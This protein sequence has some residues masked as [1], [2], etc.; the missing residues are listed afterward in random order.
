M[1]SQLFPNVDASSNKLIEEITKIRENGNFQTVKNKIGKDKLVTLIN[2]FYPKYDIKTLEKFFKVPDS[3][4]GHWFNDLGIRTTRRHIINESVAANFEHSDVFTK[5]KKAIKLSAVKIT[6]DLA[7]LIGFTLGDGAVQ[8]YMVEVFNQDRGMYDYLLNSMKKLGPVTLDQREDGLWRI[9]LSSRIISDLIKRNKLMRQ[10][11]V[12]F[13]LSDSNL[14]KYFLAALWDAEGSVLKQGKYTHI[15]FYNSNKELIDLIV[16]YLNTK[17]I[18]SSILK[19]N[20]RRKDYFINGH[21][22]KP[23]KQMY[24]IGIPKSDVGKWANEIGLY[25]LHS[26]KKKVVN[27]II[28]GA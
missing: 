20:E 15:Y 6:P 21:L 24:R 12:D 22:V 19:L 10:E 18:K 11:T 5:D 13:I 27:E 9:R 7:Y 23:I 4:L 14:A 26:K 8:K 16:G 1:V 17:D 3:T 28:N 2:K 25:L